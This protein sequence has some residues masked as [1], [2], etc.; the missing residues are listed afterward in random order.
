MT[1]DLRRVEVR[2]P[3]RCTTSAVAGFLTLPLLT[4][5]CRLFGFAAP[6]HR[7][8]YRLT[9]LLTDCFSWT[10]AILL[11]A[12]AIAVG[13][14]TEYRR[15]YAFAL[16]LPLPIAFFIEVSENPTSHNLFPFEIVLIWLPIFFLVAIGTMVGKFLRKRRLAVQK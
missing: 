15:T 7:G 16:A 4:G 9:S 5:L 3:F 11:F 12:I 14:I 1:N 6:A 2:S 13:W 8:E 10:F